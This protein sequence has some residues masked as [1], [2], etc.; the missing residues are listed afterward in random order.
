MHHFTTLALEYW[1]ASPQA[2]RSAETLAALC[3][4][5]ADTYGQPQSTEGLQA[6]AQ[7]EAE[8][9]GWLPTTSV[10]TMKTMATALETAGRQTQA[11]LDREAIEAERATKLRPRKVQAPPTGFFEQVQSELFGQ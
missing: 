11:Q 8:R 10:P 3:A 4:Q 9:R 2:P 6:D 5:L 1:Q 7:A